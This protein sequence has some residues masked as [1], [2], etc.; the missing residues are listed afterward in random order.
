LIEEERKN[1]LAMRAEDKYK[2]FLALGMVVTGSIN[3][4][5]TKWAD[6]QRA[7]GKPEF[8]EH[9]FD[10][11]FLQAVGMFIGEFTCL[12]AFQLWRRFNKKKVEDGEID[13]GSDDFSPFLLALPA[14]CDMLGTSTMYFGLTLTFASSFQ[15]L[16]G[17]V[18]LFTAIF[19]VIFLKAIIQM[20]RWAGIG[21]VIVGLAAVGISDMLKEINNGGGKDLR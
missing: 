16:R 19:S 18:M 17:A 5:S 13:V 10:H 8:P 11:P 1:F 15:M 12:I 9:D 14:C 6:N 2:L 21:V 20:F 3:T 4:I 7:I